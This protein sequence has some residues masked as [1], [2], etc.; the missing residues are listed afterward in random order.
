MPRRRIA[1][2]G[3][4]GI[5]NYGGFE[6][7][8]SELAPRLHD[9][10]YEVFCSHRM[11]ARGDARTDFKGSKLLYFPFRF[12]KSGVLARGFEAFYDWYF[13]VMCCF[14]MKCDIVYCLGTASG[15]ALPLCRLSRS[16]IVV[17]VDGVEWERAKFSRAQQNLI[18]LF[19][20]ASLIGSHSLLLDNSK[21]LDFIP[22][23]FRNKA[24]HIPYGVTSEECGNWDSR[25]LLGIVKG[26][27]EV[28]PSNYWL[29]VARLE[30]DNN[31]HTIIEGYCS[32]R[33]KMP[34]VVVGSFSSAEYERS[35]R[36]LLGAK[37][38][39]KEIVFAGSVYDQP[40]LHM[41]RCHCY[42]Y[43]HGHSVGG[44]NPSLLEAMGA[45]N[46]IVAHDNVFNRE[47]CSDFAMYFVNAKDLADR[48][49]SI[50]NDRSRFEMLRESVYARATLK[51]RW[52]D[53]AV[54]YD[55]LFQ[56]L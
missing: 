10:G 1:I 28:L 47:V 52:E 34:L 9:I 39:G 15:F 24:S 44:T 2:I 32:S 55:R 18:K 8:V 6:T 25:P 48:I 54:A 14:F 17:N 43:I 31:I 30:P 53:V 22:P 19:F 12:P 33:S 50:E 35:I 7:L 4:R 27:I 23:S 37:S 51:Y 46:L 5:G 40:R 11:P 26:E 20:Y 36:S 16:R 49:D 13:A 42:G 21:L 38:C 45:Q 41:L 56:S 3:A 29:V